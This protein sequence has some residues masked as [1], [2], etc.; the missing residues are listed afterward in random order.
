MVEPRHVD[1]THMRWRMNDSRLKPSSLTFASFKFPN[2]NAF[3]LFADQLEIRDDF[4]TVT[5]ISSVI[6]KRATV[7]QIYSRRLFV[8]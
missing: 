1:S 4:F 3:R 5:G 6:L 8:S 7:P 2:R